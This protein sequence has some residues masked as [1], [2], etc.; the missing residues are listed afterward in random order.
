MSRMY[1][2]HTVSWSEA[3]AELRLVRTRVFLQEQAVPVELEWDG[4]DAAAWHVLAR[5]GSGDAIGTARILTSG[6]IGR[7]AVLPEWRGRGVGRA[8]LQQAVGLAQQHQLPEIMLHAQIQALL[9][10]AKAGFIAVGPEFVDAGIPHRTMY[11]ACH[12]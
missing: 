3:E 5:N 9:F 7:M 10:Y 4:E 12:Q 1:T 8:L 6:Q 2:L 11:L